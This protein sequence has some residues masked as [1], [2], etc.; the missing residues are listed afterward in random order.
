M[1]SPIYQDWVKEEARAIINDGVDVPQTR[2]RA[3][4]KLGKS[5]RNIN[6]E[7]KAEVTKNE[8][9]ERR[10]ISVGEA[11]PAYALLRGGSFL[12]HRPQPH[13]SYAIST[14]VSSGASIPTE[15]TK[16]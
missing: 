6:G 16:T 9:P 2:R 12:V 3:F 8:C 10:I 15:I 5:F 14:G 13:G 4:R 1:Q 11:S 7:K